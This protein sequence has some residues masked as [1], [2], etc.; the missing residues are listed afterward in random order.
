MGFRTANI[1][2]IEPASLYITKKKQNNLDDKSWPNEDIKKDYHNLKK[3]K[4]SKDNQSSNEGGSE[5]FGS[6][7]SRKWTAFSNKRTNGGSTRGFKVKGK[8]KSKWIKSPSKSTKNDEATDEEGLETEDECDRLTFGSLFDGSYQNLINF[9]FENLI[10][11]KS[12][13]EELRNMFKNK[14]QRKIIGKDYVENQS[15][16]TYNNYN[17]GTWSPY[18]PTFPFPVNTQSYNGSN[19]NNNNMG[20]NYNSMAPTPPIQP[21]IFNSASN[22]NENVNCMNSGSNQYLGYNSV[23]SLN[24]NICSQTNLY[25][26]TNYFYNHN[27]LQSAS[28]K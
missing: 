15:K 4:V 27:A 20:Y 13:M 24:S 28:N 19:N 23:G 12:E 5:D 21:I 3:I 25:C 9:E 16:M 18:Q 7:H 6:V 2:Q 8:G 1:Q 26:N 10:Q 22:V 17:N 11:S 14:M